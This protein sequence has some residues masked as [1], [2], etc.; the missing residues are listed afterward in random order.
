MQIGTEALALLNAFYQT[1]ELLAFFGET[2]EL[3]DETGCAAYDE[4]KMLVEGYSVQ[5]LFMGFRQWLKQRELMKALDSGNKKTGSNIIKLNHKATSGVEL[6]STPGKTTTILGRFGSD[7]GAIINELNLPKSTDFSGN[8]GGF[9]L[10][11]TPDD[12]YDMLEPKGFWNE[13]NKPFLDAAISR[14][15]VIIMATPINDTNL[16]LPGSTELTGYGR[17]YFY[18]LEQGYEYINGKMV[19][20]K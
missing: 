6:K 7:T 18:L 15:D 13:Y 16:Y 14:G 11:N 12:L 4:T 19:I 17:E 9:N 2:K 20:G 1:N 10:L 3:G 5:F 8:P